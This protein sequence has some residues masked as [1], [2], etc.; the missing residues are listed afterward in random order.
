MRTTIRLLFLIPL[1]IVPFSC[2]KEDDCTA[3]E[4]AIGH[5]H[6]KIIAQNCDLGNYAKCS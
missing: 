3:C 2:L 1:F 6:E 4:K 5:M